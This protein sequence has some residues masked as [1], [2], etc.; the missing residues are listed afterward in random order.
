M[1]K[2]L[3]VKRRRDFG[4]QKWQF[5]A[6]L[7]TVVL[8]V[9]MFAGTFNAYL[10]LGSSLDETY[11]RLTMADM[12]VTGA[13]DGFVEGALALDGVELAIER[14]QADVPFEIGDDS[15]LGRIVG[16][17]ADEQPEINQ[18]DI[19]E[20][21]YLDSSDP[22]GIVL[23][24]DAAQDF[25]LGVGDSFTIAGRP[26]TVLGIGVSPEYLWLARDSQNMFTAPKSFAVA[27]VDE[28]LLADLGGPTIA[29][30][31]LV[32][33]A[34]GA[35]RADVDSDVTSAA[36]SA[37]ATETQTLE[38][39]PS[40]FTIQT[41]I[42]GLQTI[43]VA[44]PLLFLA[45][46]G[47][48]IYVVVTRM[49]FSQ[50]AVIG[51]L[52]ASGFDRRSMSR[53]YLGYGLAVGLVG[54]AI[55]VVFGALLGRGMTAL[56]TQVFGI[57]DLVAKVH[58]PTI[59]MALAFGA[60]AGTLAGIPPARTV[61]RLA[62]AEAM[63]GDVPT[64]D[65]HRSIFET[66]I[67]PLRQAPVRWRMSLRGIGRNRKRSTSMV[68]GVILGMTLI[69]A[70]WGLMDT[71]LQAIDRQFDDVQIEDASVVV[72]E[73][74]GDEQVEAIEAVDGVEVAEPVIG[75]RVTISSEADDFI[76][77]LEGYQLD[78][79]VHGFDP[80]LPE[81]GLLLGEAMEGQLG[82]SVGDSVTVDVTTLS[83]QITA[84]IAGFVDEPLGTSAY[85]ASPALPDLIEQAGGTAAAQ[86][87]TLPSISSIKAVF[88]GGADR[89][90]VISDIESIDIVVVT[91][92]S[93]DLR[94]LVENFQ[95]F[96]YAFIGM[97][98][99]FGGALAFA[100]IFNIIS[101]NVAERSGEFASMRANGLTHRR[102]AALIAGETGLLTVMGIIPGML[103]GY[104]AAVAL[105]NSF[106]S[107]EFPISA[108]IRP[109]SYV[110]AAVVMIVVAALSLIPA[111]RAVKRINVGEVVRERA[112]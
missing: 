20:G 15:L 42:G 8:G 60:V 75:L 34:D 37:G 26:V 92:D 11:D 86:A 77:L 61:S 87:L 107:P 27:F 59:L 103:V 106:S 108:N 71:M 22:S 91:I 98:L 23:Q 97:M 96:F 7:V 67:P 24:S 18:I 16:M 13:A 43:A 52:R 74:M 46:A 29:D 5:I 50:R 69:L 49:V 56:Y 30:Q 58:V 47:M 109:V 82:V 12:T 10:N 88:E 48:A 101:V 90:V 99:V 35:N 110:G 111:I 54:A 63:R 2:T 68:V 55:G 102:V 45:A 57:P 28:S 81:T 38:E 33:Y 19:E 76:T 112:A 85:M 66:L 94:D 32:S 83:T 73:P 95:V 89:E 79:R 72:S 44:L 39:Q 9:G 53:H 105:M 36:S 40:N 17:P 65:G 31:V 100:L 51:T 3:G 4:R 70:S 93:N 6:V 62:P 21:E 80:P 104:L 84:E 1:V 25:E 64:A 14:Q 41:E 78:T